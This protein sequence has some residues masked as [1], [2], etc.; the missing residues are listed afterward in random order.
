MNSS[1]D[2]W[3]EE[4]GFFPLLNFSEEDEVGVKALF[5]LEDI[6]SS[7][8]VLLTLIAMVGSLSLDVAIRE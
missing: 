4:V 8:L 6:S 2:D 1:F 3:D 7:E 5:L